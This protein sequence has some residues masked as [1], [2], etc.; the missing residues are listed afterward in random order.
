MCGKTAGSGEKSPQEGS[1]IKVGMCQS[2]FPLDLNVRP[3]HEHIPNGLSLSR[4]SQHREFWF[5]RIR[6][7]NPIP[8]FSPLSPRAP[9][10][11]VSPWK[12]TGD[13]FNPKHSLF[14]GIFPSLFRPEGSCSGSCFSF[15]KTSGG[16]SLISSTCIPRTDWECP[17]LCRGNAEG[18]AQIPGAKAREKRQIEG[19]PIPGYCGW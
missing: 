5:Q 15:G 13:S 10:A 14:Q 18:K 16:E 3:L 8:T 1:G 19:F 2:Q 11:P 7:E 17:I 9:G 4:P 6:L 12:T